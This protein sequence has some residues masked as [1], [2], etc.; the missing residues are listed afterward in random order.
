MRWTASAS[1]TTEPAR[2]LRGV[3]RARPSP[4]IPSGGHDLRVCQIRGAAARVSPERMSVRLTRGARDHGLSR[5]S[6]TSH[7]SGK[8]AP[9]ARAVLPVARSPRT[10]VSRSTDKSRDARNPKP[11]RRPTKPWCRDERHGARRS[12]MGL[13]SRGARDSGRGD[14]PRDPPPCPCRSNMMCSARSALLPEAPIWPTLPPVHSDLAHLFP[15][16]LLVVIFLL[17][18]SETPARRRAFHQANRARLRRGSATTPW[19]CHLSRRGAP[20]A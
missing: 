19:K 2:D 17:S 16:T 13:R 7:R 9:V 15:A 11:G 10:L 6:G 3:D 18:L 12:R 5:F 14:T 1:A 4:A 8:Y 20:P